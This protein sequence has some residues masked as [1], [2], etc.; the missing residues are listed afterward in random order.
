[1]FFILLTSGPGSYNVPDQVSEIIKKN[2]YVQYKS[3]PFEVY[4]T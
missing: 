4:M 3:V 1:M 2:V